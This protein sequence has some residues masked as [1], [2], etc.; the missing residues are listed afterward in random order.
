MRRAALLAAAALLASAAP[1]TAAAAVPRRATAATPPVAAM[2]I[3][4]PPG[5]RGD[6]GRRLPAGVLLPL[7]AFD[8]LAAAVIGAALRWDRPRCVAQWL[9]ERDAPRRR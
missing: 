4:A 7:I 1:A 5:H 9:P 8:L 2:V 6:A 3:P